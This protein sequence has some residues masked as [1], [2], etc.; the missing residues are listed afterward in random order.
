MAGQLREGLGSDWLESLS[1]IRPL[2]VLD[3]WDEVG[4]AKQP[5]A[6]AW[7]A[8]LCDRFPSAHIIVTTRPEGSNDPIFREQRFTRTRMALL[9]EEKKLEIIERW[10]LGIKGN[11]PQSPD[12]DEIYLANAQ[13]KLL[14]D[15]RTPNLSKLAETPLLVAMLCCLYAKSTRRNPVSKSVL[16][17]TVIAVLI[18]ERDRDREIKSGIWDDLYFGQKETF[19]G[20]IA[21]TMSKAGTLTLPLDVRDN[22]VSIEDIAR[23]VL[24]DFGR[25]QQA[26]GT[27]CTAAFER[28]GV[29][30]RVEDDKGEFA[31]RTFQDYF[32]GV[33]LA[34]N[35]D[36]QVLF[37][38]AQKEIYLG[39]LP[40]AIRAA[41]PE[42][43]NKIMEWLVFKIDS[44]TNND[45]YRALAFAAVECLNAAVSLEPR[46]RAE[47][48]RAVGPLFPPENSDD[49]AALAAVGDAAVD[50]LRVGIASN[51]ERYCIEALSLIGTPRA[52][53]ALREY[54]LTRGRAVANFLIAAWERLP[55]KD[56]SEAVLSAIASEVNVK[57]H[58]LG[59]LRLI[60]PI[61]A[62]SSIKVEG[63]D[64][65]QDALAGLASLPGLRDLAITNCL[66][67][68]DC[69][70][71]R[72]LTALDTLH[73]SN[74]QDLTSITMPE[75]HRIR[76]LSLRDLR[77]GRIVWEEVIG[78]LVDLRVL[79]IECVEQ[80]AGSS[81][82][83]IDP[84][85][86]VLMN[87][88]HLKTLV[89]NL[90][91]GKADLAFLDHTPNLSIFSHAGWVDEEALRRIGRL[92]K[93]RSAHLSFASG[94]VIDTDLSPLGSL[95]MLRDVSLNGAGL[96]N[97]CRLNNLDRIT[98]LRC[99]NA[100][101]PGIDSS[102]FPSSLHHLE[103]YACYGLESKLSGRQEFRNVKSLIWR[104][105]GLGNLNF[106]RNF[107]ALESLD[108][109]DASDLENVDGVSYLP[110]GCRA[111]I[112][113]GKSSA[114]HRAIMDAQTRCAIRYEPRESWEAR[115]SARDDLAAG[116]SMQEVS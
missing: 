111:R 110:D 3:G 55:E 84:S 88:T 64:L 26:A 11:L 75:S 49:A 16:Y 22:T 65:S 21:L 67:L 92:S 63:I 91:R 17:E 42:L 62:I 93:L 70:S 54:A 14:R 58:S 27:L 95:A 104:G 5:L 25:S 100:R 113:G 28:S 116:P 13:T 10:F 30:Q 59:Q 15:I 56:Y 50:F 1:E 94:D 82:I 87:S 96:G 18:H 99:M 7:L 35:R 98:K 32:A 31:H 39:I 66:G 6:E 90:G 20:S 68:K 73:L 4:A 44:C 23:E 78:A 115:Y 34:H 89:L 77:V 76:S 60:P 97:G 53:N 24:P 47:A 72:R 74:M 85:S 41:D 52:V 45:L 48:V 12:L 81:T 57:I 114:D 9:T 101:I 8:S 43:A 103:F 19:L 80:I 36:A 33:L 71:L 46:V 37:D 29:L 106:L 51:L 105:P 40:F 79:W 102:V 69:S 107:P 108:I 61:K 38:L 83:T 86:A 109:I 2:L 112:M